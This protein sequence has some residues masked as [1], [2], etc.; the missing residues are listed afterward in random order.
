MSCGNTD[1]SA[2]TT[3][4]CGISLKSFASSIIIRTTIVILSIIT[5]TFL[6][7]FSFHYYAERDDFHL[8][9][10]RNPMLFGGGVASGV[11]H[12]LT[13]PDHLLSI[14]PRIIGRRFWKGCRVGSVWGFGHAIST[15]FIGGCVYIFKG[16]ILN[17]KFLH[18]LVN[19]NSFAIGFTLVIIGLMGLY[20]NGHSDV[21][22]KS[23]DDEEP[24]EQANIKPINTAKYD[25]VYTAIFFN[26]VFLGCS[27]DGLPSLAPTLATTTVETVLAFLVGNFLGTVFAISICSGVIAEASSL[28]SRV[29]SESFVSRL[30]IG[31]AL[32]AMFI[33][34][35][36]ILIAFLRT[37]ILSG[38]VT[39]VILIIFVIGMVSVV[40]ALTYGLNSNDLYTLV[41]TRISAPVQTMKTMR[42]NNLKESAAVDPETEILE[43]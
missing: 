43:P 23:K 38:T 25:M 41:C 33:G 37:N 13:G 31:S 18:I 14:L 39:I 11:L 22:I 4:F 26:G 27:W 7:M 35:V 21:C 32:V 9:F 24:N 19:L 6:I 2:A 28:L 36:M 3:E 17:F 42:N 29:S 20:E 34:S 1:L 16:A 5:F 10:L 12:A 30:C 8:F 15:T 40:F